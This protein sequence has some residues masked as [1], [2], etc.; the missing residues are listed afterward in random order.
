V[1]AFEMSALIDGRHE[2]RALP[3]VGVVLDWLVSSRIGYAAVDGVLIAPRGDIDAQGRQPY[4]RLLVTHHP[5]HGVAV[6]L[7]RW[8][9][10]DVF[11]SSAPRPG[12]PDV[13]VFIPPNVHE[14][15]PPELFVT[16]S[17]AARAIE[18]ALAHGDRHPELFWIA[19][20]N[21][22]RGKAE[23]R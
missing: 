7:M 10:P 11:V 2:T 23:P 22:K 19:N 21:F 17:I 1:Q 9:G 20:G 15:W 6:L 12:R 14:L 4:P 8:D 13:Y 16:P 5:G 18:H 3:P